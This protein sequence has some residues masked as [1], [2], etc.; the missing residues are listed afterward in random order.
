MSRPEPIPPG[1]AP[2]PSRP[3]HPSAERRPP[4]ACHRVRS[5]ATPPSSAEVYPAYAASQGRVSSRLVPGATLPA[6]DFQLGTAQLSG[7]GAFATF[8]AVAAP[9]NVTSPTP[10]TTPGSCFPGIARVIARV[11]W[12][13]S[14]STATTL[15]PTSWNGLIKGVCTYDGSSYFVVG[16]SSTIG[17]GWKA[18]GSTSAPLITQFASA[19][20]QYV[21]C[22]VGATSRSVYMVRSGGVFAYVDKAATA[23]PGAASVA[24][25]Q[26]GS[27]SSTPYTA[28]QV[29]ANAAETRFFVAVASALSA[30][31][32]GIYTGAALSGM[33]QMVAAT[34]KATGVS[35]SR[36][37]ATLF[38]TARAPLNALYS[39]ATS[40]S[41]ACTPT[42]LYTADANTQLR[43]CFIAPAQ[44]A[45]S[46]ASAAPSPSASP[47]PASATPSVSPSPMPMAFSANSLLV[48]R[49]GSGAAPLTDAAAAVFIDEYDATTVSSTS[50]PI[51]SRQVSS[52]E[53][54][55]LSGTDWSQGTLVRA[56]DGASVLFG[57][58]R[59]AV[60]TAAT[61]TAPFM[62]GDRVLVRL[63]AGGVV[64]SSTTVASS[65]YDGLIKTACALNS[66]G[67]W[68][69]GNASLI[70]IGYV[71]DGSTSTVLSQAGTANGDYSTCVFSPAGKLYVFHSSATAF[72]FNTFAN[73]P[74]TGTV[75]LPAPV[76][77]NAGIQGKQL[78]LNAAETK[79]WVADVNA[80]PADAGVYYSVLPALSTLS[81]MVGGTYRVTALAL[82]ADEAKLFMTLRLPTFGL[83]WVASTCLAACVPT[84]L[85]PAAANT[86]FRGL[87][88]APGAWV[89]SPTPTPSASPSPN[90]CPVGQGFVVPPK[91]GGGVGPP[92]PG[93]CKPCG[94]GSTNTA[95]G[96][97]VCTCT[98]AGASWSST[99]NTCGCTAPLSTLGVVGGPC[100]ACASSCGVGS[101]I[102]G[103]CTPLTNIA[104]SLCSACGDGEIASQ[105]CGTASNTVCSQC[106]AGSF[107]LAGAATCTACGAGSVPAESRGGC[108]CSDP[109]AV[110]SRATNTCA[111]GYGF[112]GSPGSCTANPAAVTQTPTPSTTPSVTP[113]GSTSPTSSFSTGASQSPTPST[114][115]TISVTSSVTYSTSLS[116]SITRSPS[117]TPSKGSP[118]SSS[119][120][121]MSSAVS[122]GSPLPGASSSSQPGASA[123]ASAGAGL[124]S[125][126]ISG[127]AESGGGGISGTA[128]GG[129]LVGAIAVTAAVAYAAHVRSSAA[130]GRALAAT[131]GGV[132]GVGVGGGG[133]YAQPQV[134]VNANPLQAAQA[135]GAFTVRASFQPQAAGGNLAAAT[136]WT[137]CIEEASSKRW[138]Y[139]ESTGQTVWALPPGHT[140]ARQLVQ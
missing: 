83:Y 64:Q 25:A 75:T 102:A 81:A 4:T 138:Y 52:T 90:V 48:L 129:I 117:I 120:T 124:G 44:A 15:D 65:I 130:K 16:N 61:A 88:F 2:R 20:S 122:G 50:T 58:V 101:Y 13:G 41:A 112:T 51:S 127:G 38:F 99:T 54:V 8:A 28:K 24:V 62:A 82:S 89:P 46:V 86:E 74:T 108:V 29:V 78:V 128:L 140:I 14:V 63:T 118:P 109:N 68:I 22:A 73:M 96:S 57:A 125:G 70:G 60:G 71:V 100:V 136:Q 36:D 121:P 49:V 27:M 105:A 106:A 85:L 6:N 126:A 7:D 123:S 111:C 87:A 23:V 79:M 32:G 77:F 110:W 10:C 139:N 133:G 134:L 9:V 91:A 12:D 5:P 72:F 114:S 21:A 80:I 103:P 116:P 67:A 35:L 132:G 33:T 56:A 47:L 113:A 42:L 55:A 135:S 119:S 45:G 131:A 76:L 31:D 97:G 59:A 84:L 34:Y 11:S 104:C 18:H 98:D 137:E 66:N 30:S 69:V 40:C 37:E 17:L 1:P 94:P 26:S 95:A 39:V 107:A 43:G 19:A 53:G 3:P 115:P 92:P 93:S